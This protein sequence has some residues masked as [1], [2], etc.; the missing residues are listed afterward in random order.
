MKYKLIF[1][2]TIIL[3]SCDPD[4]KDIFNTEIVKVNATIERNT[5][6]INLGDTIVISLKIP[7]TLT[8]SSNIKIVESLQRGQF[9][10]TINKMD[11]LTRIG[12]AL[13]PPFIWLQKGSMEGNLSFVCNN[14]QKP[15]STIVYCKPQEKGLYYIEI[16]NQ[17]GQFK[18]NNNYDARLV[19]NF[20]VPNKHINILSIIS[21]FFGGQLF[22]DGILQK[23]AD[24]FG[25]YFFRVT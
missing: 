6:T 25:V 12:K 15:Y 14:D 20:N 10:M 7:D 23:D 9:G 22:Y 1:F 4:K 18:I 19:V 11:T 17:A 3:I 24:G 5:E 21:P 2:L 16:I 8:T 13:K